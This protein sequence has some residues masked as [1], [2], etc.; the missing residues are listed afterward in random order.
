MT[1]KL[2]YR[3][4]TLDNR[5]LWY[6]K[7]GTY[8]GRMSK[9]FSFCK[10]ANLPM[11]F[12]PELVGFLSV[13]DTLEQLTEWLP[14]IDAEKLRYHGFQVYEF[15]A[16]NYRAYENHYLICQKTSIIK[17]ELTDFYIQNYKGK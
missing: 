6:D 8:S 13:T 2:F 5:G 1:T 10:N 3:V 17:R 11:P 14:V 4:G 12:N 9:E 15:E 16:T 7:D